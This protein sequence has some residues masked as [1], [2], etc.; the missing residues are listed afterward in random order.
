[1]NRR[2]KTSFFIIERETAGDRSSTATSVQQSYSLQYIMI[3]IVGA[4]STIVSSAQLNDT[5]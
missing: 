2:L 1:M 3:I 4:Q 5:C